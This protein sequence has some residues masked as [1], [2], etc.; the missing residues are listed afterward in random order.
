MAKKTKK[1]LTQKQLSKVTGGT[2]S[3]EVLAAIQEQQKNDPNHNLVMQMS[4]DPAF[5]TVPNAGGNA[6]YMNRMRS[7]K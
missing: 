6:A 2:I 1:E 7:I 3:P 5:Q 4:M